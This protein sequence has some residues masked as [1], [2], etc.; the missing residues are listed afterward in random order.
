MAYSY[1]APVEVV[2]GVRVVSVTPTVEAGAYAAGDV[3]GGKM[4]FA[5]AVRTS[6]GAAGG[7][8][9]IQSITVATKATTTSAQIDVLL[10][11]ADP[12][13]STFTENGAIAV[14]ATDM[15]NLIGVVHVTDWTSCG[16]PSVGFG[17][18]LAIPFSLAGTSLYAVMVTRG[19][20]TPA[21][22]SDL[23]VTVRV[24]AD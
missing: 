18:S 4:T 5:N 21:S 20:I 8:G 1:G 6:N 9:L 19:A 2:G 17:G 14:N 11:N 23:I 12:S 13:A 3:I 10:F 7:T 16:T 24:V 22:T 15:A